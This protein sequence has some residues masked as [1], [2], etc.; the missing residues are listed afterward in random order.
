MSA[1][2]GEGRAPSEKAQR[3]I[4]PADIRR[5][6]IERAHAEEAEWAAKSGPVT[7]RRKDETRV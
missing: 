1:S 5:I 6:E 2:Q 7:V 4:T 3:L